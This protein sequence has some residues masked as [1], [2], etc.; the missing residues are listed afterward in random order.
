MQK[1]FIE[2]N[3]WLIIFTTIFLALFSSIN[4][5]SQAIPQIRMQTSTYTPST[6]TPIPYTPQTA[7][8]SILYRS[9]EK[10]EARRREA[11][12]ALDKLTKEC[13]LVSEKLGSAHRAWIQHYTDSVC[14]RVSNLIEIGDP[15]TATEAA[16]EAINDLRLNQGIHYRID[17]YSDYV[18]R[19]NRMQ[20]NYTNGDVNPETYYVWLNKNQYKFIPKY[21]SKG[22][23]IGYEPCHVSY[24]EKDINWDEV[25]RYVTSRG[26]ANVDLLWN[27]YF[28]D[29]ACKAS[30]RQFYDTL[31]TLLHIYEKN[32]KK[33]TLSQ[34]DRATTESSVES[35]KKLLYDSNHEPSMGI[36]IN[37]IRNSMKK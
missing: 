20:E 34:E 15:S 23:V 22:S 5:M 12:E 28:A 32:L 18:H 17:S 35:L 21:N 19:L 24:L 7:D 1:S 33:N 37:N 11:Y 27:A 29:Y 3:A 8:R 9:M 31:V 13:N 36:M 6:F 10:R 4:G 14:G 25:K 30:L 26:V 2:R 16:Y